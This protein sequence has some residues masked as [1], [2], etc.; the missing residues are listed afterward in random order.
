MKLEIR[1]DSITIE[2]YVNIPERKS[3]VMPSI[4][5]KFTESIN[6][7]VFQRAIDKADEIKL[8]FN[9][10]EKRQLGSTKDN[11]ILKEDQIGLYAKAEINDEE[12]R[13]LAIENK[14][15]GWS[16]GFRTNKDVWS[17]GD[18]QHR[19]IE[20]LDLLEVSVL[21]V[22]PAY[23]STKVESRDSKEEIIEHR[24]I[25]EISVEV[26]EEDVNSQDDNKSDEEQRLFLRQ[27]QR[28]Q[29]IKKKG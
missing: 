9:H 12:V 19:T 2:G 28:I 24:A 23:Y 25:D 21:S 17:D 20:D 5:G 27:K 10:N 13:Q 26:K 14:L 6:G 8:L 3:R 1:N 16:F 22:K 15:T 11:L 29:I 4:R 7:G 18:I